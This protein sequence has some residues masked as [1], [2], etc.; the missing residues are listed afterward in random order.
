MN[1]TEPQKAVAIN[2]LGLRL[3]PSELEKTWRTANAILLGECPLDAGLEAFETSI[4]LCFGTDS[5]AAHNAMLAG[6]RGFYAL[7]E[8]TNP[9]YTIPADQILDWW[10]ATYAGTPFAPLAQ[11]TV[12]L[13]IDRANLRMSGPE[14]TVAG[15]KITAEERRDADA[16]RNL[17]M[18]FAKEIDETLEELYLDKD[19]LERGK[20]DPNF[21][22]KSVEDK[23][24][25][26][27][28]NLSHRRELAI[29][30]IRIRNPA[31]PAKVI[32]PPYLELFIRI[33]LK[34]TEV[35]N[36]PDL[37]RYEFAPAWL[38]KCD[39]RTMNLEDPMTAELHCVSFADA[40]ISGG[41]AMSALCG[42][43]GSTRASELYET[44]YMAS[45]KSAP[46]ISYSDFCEA[47][48]YNTFDPGNNQEFA[49][50]HKTVLE[51]IAAHGR[52]ASSRV[53]VK[54]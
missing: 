37:T 40:K 49:K 38:V 53:S 25:A 19:K 29:Q 48:T 4:R 28:R 54:G 21:L 22:Q 36:N 7:P 52:Y 14:S 24:W 13:M 6:Y 17:W 12:S 20:G 42:Q 41:P 2:H 35:F 18:D 10:Q 16:A 44:G 9:M 23:H 26:A 15:V 3:L 30:L 45:V 39:K 31:P 46:K 27:F 5:L 32:V 51:F 50:R 43:I 47:V 33:S 8:N 11:A 34:E 1:F